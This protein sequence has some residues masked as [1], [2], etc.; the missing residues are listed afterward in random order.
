MEPFITDTRA[1]ICMSFAEPERD[2]GPISYG[3]FALAAYRLCDQRL[4]GKGI[5]MFY[6]KSI[7]IN[8]RQFLVLS[9]TAAAGWLVG[10]ATN[11]VT[12]KNQLMLVSEQQEIAMDKQHS[13]HQLS[14]DY[15]TVQDLK[16]NDYVS[17]TSL[18]LAGLTHRPQMPYSFRVVNANYVNA[19]AFP[20][21]TIAATR[22]IMLKM[23]NEGELAALMGHELGHVNARHTA[24]IMSK[25]Q[26]T[27]LVVG[28][29]SVYVSANTGYGDLASQLGMLG[30]GALLASYSRDNERQADSLGMEYM[31]KAGYGPDGMVGLMNILN[32]LSKGKH[33]TAELLF[34][35]HPMSSERYNTAVNTARKTYAGAKRQPLYSE[36]YMDHTAG[37]RRIQGPIE[38]MQ[39]GEAQM[40]KK[41]YG[42][43]EELFTKALKKAPKDYTGLVLMAK[44]QLAQKKTDPA[45]RYLE[46][47]RQVYPQE[48]QAHYLDGF[49]KIKKKKYDAALERLGTYDKQLPGNPNTTFFKGVAYEGKGVKKTA[50]DHYY[51]YLQAVNQ[52]GNAK[53]AYNRLVEWG[54]IKKQ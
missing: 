49:V 30:S 38:E 28:G 32:T 34:S 7:P 1:S 48:A 37:L 14:A 21:G 11:P 33:S 12:G 35:T 50:A 39:K 47:A 9:S 3:C 15:G 44:C 25:S 53:Y 51:K 54:Y 24:E 27:N 16:L 13:P 8:R 31:V 43:A 5:E 45:E 4:L 52:G 46:T 41:N 26:L 42:A 36:R 40:G 2:T 20:G 22:G 10:C 29:L 19:Y 17:K 18:K 6:K 23:R